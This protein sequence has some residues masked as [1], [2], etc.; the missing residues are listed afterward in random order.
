MV[1]IALVVSLLEFGPRVEVLHGPLS[2]EKRLMNLQ[3]QQIS[4]NTQIQ[5]RYVAYKSIP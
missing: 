2:A 3:S 1:H 4:T 5:N